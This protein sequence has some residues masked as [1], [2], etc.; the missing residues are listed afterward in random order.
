MEITLSGVSKRYK[1]KYALKDFTATLGEGVYG[2]LG[3]NGAG[4]TTLINTFVG[5][6]RGDS[7]TIRVDGQD[8]RTLGK[9]FLSQIGY[10]PQYPIFYRDFTVKDFLLYSICVR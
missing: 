2:L 3:E 5:I 7:G 9:A 10:M 8:V 6:L 4:K 1:S